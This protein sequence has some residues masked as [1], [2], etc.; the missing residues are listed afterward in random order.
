MHNRTFTF[1][2]RE[3]NNILYFKKRQQQICRSYTRHV[4]IEHIVSFSINIPLIVSVSK[5]EESYKQTTCIWR[6]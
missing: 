2:Y 4:S 6:K 3:T 5:L 1:I